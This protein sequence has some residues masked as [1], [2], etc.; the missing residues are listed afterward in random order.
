VLNP[1]LPVKRKLVALKENAGSAVVKTE[2]QF[3]S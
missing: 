1:R 2:L 3:K